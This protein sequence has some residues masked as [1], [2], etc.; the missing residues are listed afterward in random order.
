MRCK[1]HLIQSEFLCVSK[2]YVPVNFNHFIMPLMNAILKEAKDELERALQSTSME[3]KTL[4]ITIVNK[5]YAKEDGVLDVF[6]QSLSLGEDT[7]HLVDH[8]L[9]VAVDQAALDRCR[10]LKL[11]CY[12][13]STDG[14]DFSG[15]EIYMSGEFI[16][17]MWRR[18]LFLID[19]LRR[20]YNF[21]F[22][23]NSMVT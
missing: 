5:A 21:I 3:N 13:L 23:V 18:T 16:S 4:I 17:M 7:Q 19:V 22:T 2:I 6:L 15:E 1:R 9:V 10:Q 20:G 8:L 11:L 12:Q 14:V